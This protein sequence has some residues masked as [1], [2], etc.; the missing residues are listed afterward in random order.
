MPRQ[1]W[2]FN[3]PL[4]FPESLPITAHLDAIRT[5]LDTH[6]IIVV[7]GETGSGK[8]TQLPKLMLAL[9]RGVLKQIGHTQPR[10]IAAR[11]V[12]QRLAEELNVSLGDAVG[13]QIRFQQKTSAETYIKIMTDGI[14]L[15]ELAADHRLKK[16]DTLIIDEAHER[17]LNI[18]F[19]LGYLKWLLPKRPDLKVIITSATLDHQR[20]SH[21]FN[22]CPVIEVSGRSFPVEIRYQALADDNKQ[23]LDSAQMQNMLTAIES[24]EDPTGDILIFLSGE[25]AI[26]ESGTY[27]R[28]CGL[29]HTEILPLYAKLSSHEQQK[30]FSPTRGMR[31]IILATNIA[32]TSLT[33][34]HI[35]YVIDTGVARIKRYN[36]RNKIQ[37]LPIEAISRASAEQRAGRCGRTA[38]GVCIRL[39]SAED[40]ALRPAFTEPEILRSH[41]AHVVLHMLQLQIGD[42]ENFPWL[43]PPETR[44][45]KDAYQ[46]LEELGAIDFDHNHRMQLTETG[47]LMARLPV[48]PR[49]AKFLIQGAANNCL[50]LMRIIASALSVADIFLHP[51]DKRQAANEKHRLFFNPHSDFATLLNVWYVLQ[52]KQTSLSQQACKN[53]CDKHFLSYA[54]FKEWQDLHD[55]LKQ[56]T[57]E[58]L[59]GVLILDEAPSIADDEYKPCEAILPYLSAQWISLHQS[60]LSGLLTHVAQKQLQGNY[61]AARLRQVKLFPTSA[62][63]KKPP[64][65]MMAMELIETQHPYARIAAAIEP[66]WVETLAPHLIK[67]THS[68]PHW[69]AKRGEV[70]AWEKVLFFGLTL[71]EK[72][73]VRYAPI[74]ASLNH[75]I[76]L[77]EA[78]AQRQLNSSV[79]FWQQNELFLQELETLEEKTRVRY[80]VPDE[81]WLYNFY[82][83]KIPLTIHSRSAC[84]KWWQQATQTEQQMLFL[85]DAHLTSSP[86]Q[87][88]TDNYPSEWIWQENHLKILYQFSP[89]HPDDGVTLIVPQA[90]LAALP[91]APFTWLV[92]GLLEEKIHTLLKGLPKEQRKTLIPLAESAQHIRQQLTIQPEKDFFMLLAH[93]ISAYCGE[94]I[95]AASLKNIPLPEFLK[96]NF[97]IVSEEKI[98]AQGRNLS[99]L[100]Q[101]ALPNNSSIAAPL[102]TEHYQAW[103]MIDL[104]EQKKMQQDGVMIMHYLALQSQ[105]TAVSIQTLT[106]LPIAKQTHQ[107]GV[108]KLLQIRAA[109]ALCYAIKKYLHPALLAAGA[110]IPLSNKRIGL[111]KNQIAA[112]L[113]PYSLSLE[114]IEDYFSLALI[115][116]TFAEDFWLIRSATVFEE[117]YQTHH[118]DL[119]TNA[120]MLTHVIQSL[121]SQL[122]RIQNTI[123]LDDLL[124]PGFLVQTP[125]EWLERYPFY[126]AARIDANEQT[127]DSA[128][129]AIKQHYQ[130]LLDKTCLTLNYP[131]RFS[132][133]ITDNPL[134]F[135]EPLGSLTEDFL[136]IHYL[137]HELQMSRQSPQYKP[138]ESVSIARL[139]KLL[140]A[141][142]HRY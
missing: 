38:A 18:D 134:L 107:L 63:A 55:E 37:H 21:H 90:L 113:E 75:E 130:L 123:D 10:R 17:S 129:S 13:Y 77:R 59:P 121:I 8:T 35:R 124:Y 112:R 31:R 23:T 142:S 51:L 40:F 50:S 106:N 83:N 61:L 11:S 16:Y 86:N 24:F 41:L 34:P 97:H 33:I 6:Q 12:A 48:D 108:N 39:Y 36:A 110:N 131:K 27:L 64:A 128:L 80:F 60:L 102:V 73:R 56:I 137:L 78:L 71:I 116:M 5:A 117:C 44:Y 19:I 20:F 98:I 125:W 87:N 119:M 62:L 133:A 120:E 15:A 45:W 43:D 81:E 103:P 94:T 57:N 85:T 65:W 26:R 49:L 140:D 100:K 52:N 22:Q 7:A 118:R 139:Q 111:N 58:V 28:Q 46:C 92:P 9:G 42:A 84:E 126:L 29:R 96:F 54:K 109:D 4:E 32:E 47:R 1:P 95:S 136:R 88:M 91:E 79:A 104:P 74:D 82:K 76:F 67:K 69:D 132:A 89:D 68:A 105:A 114:S 122:L 101:Q 138:I 115:N 3:H 25:R 30:I 93:N 127:S 99:W 14:L 72:R 66:E 2:L 70:I 53:F 135:F 141:L